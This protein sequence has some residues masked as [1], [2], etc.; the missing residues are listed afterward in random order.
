MCWL[1]LTQCSQTI[2]PAVSK[3]GVIGVDHG[4]DVGYVL[5]RVLGS[6]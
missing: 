5:L 6:E 2:G 3:V 4:K 1:G